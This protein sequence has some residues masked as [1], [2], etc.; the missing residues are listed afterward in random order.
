MALSAAHGLGRGVGH[1]RELSQRPRGVLIGLLRE[2]VVYGRHVGALVRAGS[3][4]PVHLADRNEG[5]D[6]TRWSD[7]DAEILLEEGRRQIDRQHEDLERVRARAQVL[8]TVG[9]ALEGATAALRST[10]DDSSSEMV[11]AVWWLALAI[12]AWSILGAAATA[13]VRADMQIIHASVLSRYEPP[14]LQRVANDYAAIVPDGE[15]QVAARLTNLRH[16]VTFLLISAALSL[17]TWLWAHSTE[18]REAR[19]SQAQAASS[20]ERIARRIED[21]RRGDTHSRRK[22]KPCR[23]GPGSKRC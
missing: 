12:G 3:A 17:T 6:V 14:V 22:V 13:V 4:A 16:A 10:V 18:L 2:H 1:H 20:A 5:A 9:L 7:A 8:L 19:S 11:P 21:Q 15:N 23:E